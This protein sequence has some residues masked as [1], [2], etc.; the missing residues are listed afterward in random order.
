MY[1]ISIILIDIDNLKVVNDK[2]GHKAGDNIICK[3]SELLN[4]SFRTEDITARI[5][6]DEFA[7]L[8]PNLDSKG[9]HKIISR[10]SRIID[11]YNSNIEPKDVQK[12]IS[13]SYGT[14]TAENPK[15]MEK[16]LTQF[17][18]L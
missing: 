15:E 13:I 11:I 12:R 9:I 17:R 5:G 3:L 8:I 4:Q 16:L 6:G 1:P 10:L 7:V 18:V 14:A 2:F